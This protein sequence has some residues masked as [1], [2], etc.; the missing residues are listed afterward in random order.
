MGATSEGRNCLAPLG[1]KNNLLNPVSTGCPVAASVITS[2][3]RTAPTGGPLF[4]SDKFHNCCL[5]VSPA[6]GNCRFMATCARSEKPASMINP[7]SKLLFILFEIKCA[8]IVYRSHIALHQVARNTGQVT[9]F[10]GY[11]H[12]VLCADAYAAIQI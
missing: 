9:I 1:N 4:T 8:C 10:I 2:S 7:N 6:G 12:L 11:I 3:M 5:M